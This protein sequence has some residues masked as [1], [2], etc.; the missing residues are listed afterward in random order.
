MRFSLCYGIIFQ[1]LLLYTY[2]FKA[3]K[4]DFGASGWNH[5]SWVAVYG[6]QLNGY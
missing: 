1:T 2:D 4:Q 6:W 3:S 5:G